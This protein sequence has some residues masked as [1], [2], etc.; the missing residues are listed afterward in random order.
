[1]NNNI[2]S[3]TIRTRRMETHFLHSGEGE[4]VLLLHGWPE[5]SHVWR[6]VINRLSDRFELF[7]PDFRG[8]G[9]SQK[10]GSGP[11]AEAGPDVLAAD[12]LDLADALNIE[13]FGLVSHDV[14]AYVAQ[15][16][17]QKAPGRLSGLFFF[18]VPYPG[19][20]SRWLAPSH[21]LETWYQAFHQMPWAAQLVGASRD[22][23]RTY[24][25][26]FLRHW[27]CD[28]HT[29]DAE[30]ETWVDNFMIPGNIQGGFNWYL[31]AHQVRMAAIEGR[32]PPAPP[33]QV[34]T[35]V[36]WGA[37]DP[38]VKAEWADRLPEF[39]TNVR[40]T[41]APGAGHFVHYEKPDA[42]S[43]EIAEFFASL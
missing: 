17:A 29:F 24:F 9:A 1:M 25:G 12:I 21:V 18:N 2:N 4:R 43:F 27:A 14:G 30:L 10:F 40:A 20:G 23:C 5:W 3:R 19:I 32:T 16:I 38:I 33:I 8:F 39:F 22:T 42:A 7:A 41:V 37:E 34:P 36:F 6:R 15:V 31:S 11:S 35:R 28:E 26:A 13:R